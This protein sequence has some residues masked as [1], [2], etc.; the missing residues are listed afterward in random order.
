MNINIIASLLANLTNLKT[1]WKTSE[2]WVALVPGV[3]AILAIFGVGIDANSTTQLITIA[4]AAVSAVY[5]AGRTF[6]KAVHIGHVANIAALLKQLES[7][8]VHEF[9]SNPQVEYA[10]STEFPKQPKLDNA[11]EVAPS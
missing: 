1:G 10:P 7:E 4:W 2:F 3:V 11:T 5:V 9:A 8:F 6:L